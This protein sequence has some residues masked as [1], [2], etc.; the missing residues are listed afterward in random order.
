[1][2][3]KE[4]REFCASVKA[5]FPGMFRDVSVLDVGSL[6]INGSNRSLFEGARYL[7]I[8]LSEGPNVDRVAFVH[9]L[10]CDT[11]F[12]TIVSTEAFE[13]DYFFPQSLKR[14]IEM[15]RPGGL[16][17]FSAAGPNR[18]EHGTLRTTP[19]DS[20]FTCL[21]PGQENYYRNVT[22]E[23]IYELVDLDAVFQEFS[24]SYGRDRHDIYFWGIKR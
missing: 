20:P 15:L 16:L 13:H 12:D 7:G 17:V 3:H 24:I 1:M 18:A 14:C 8:D 5:R 22:E 21:I 23:W 10:E 6:D 4:Q 11:P 19:G 9:Q 2:S